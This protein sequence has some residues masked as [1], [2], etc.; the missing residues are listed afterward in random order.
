MGEI[1]VTVEQ[2]IVKI[3]LEFEDGTTKDISKGMILSS[4]PKNEDE[5][6]MNVQCCHINGDD[7]DNIMYGLSQLFK[8]D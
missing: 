4:K 8:E 2:A 3:I 7:Y 6:I 1:K 5:I